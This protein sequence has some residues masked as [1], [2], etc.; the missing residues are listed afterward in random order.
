MNIYVGNLLYTITGEDLKEIFEEYGVVNSAKVITDRESGRSKGYGFIEMAED[1]EARRAVAELNG[2]DVE[3]R[4][5]VVRES[6]DRR[7][8]NTQQQRRGG[9]GNFR[10]DNNDRRDFS[11]RDNDRRDFGRDNDRRSN[12]RRSY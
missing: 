8:N 9:G 4:T 7:S 5:M 2:A 10:R 11:R 6:E 3:G 1:N 12:Y